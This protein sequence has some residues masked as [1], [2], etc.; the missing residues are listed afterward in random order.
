MKNFI[1]ALLLL[2]LFAHASEPLHVF[3]SVVPQKFFVEN[4]GGEH[5]SVDVLVRPGHNPATYNPTSRQMQRFAAADVLFRIGVPFESSWLGRLSAANETLEII[6]A[7]DGIETLQIAAHHGHADDHDEH[8]EHAETDP[9]I[10]TSPLVA[11]KM[12]IQIKQVLSRLQPENAAYFEARYQ[13]LQQQLQQLHTVIS[14]QLAP[15]AGQKFIVFHPSWGYFADTYQLEQV[16]IEVDG[17][18][19]N[20]RML[21]KQVKQAHNEDIHVIFIQPQFSQQTARA[22]ADAIDGEIITIDPLAEDYIHNME[23]VARQ[24]AD[25]FSR[26]ATR[27]Q[28][29]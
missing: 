18:Q 23:K 2:P 26:T 29:K 15:Y 19:P 12:L 11:Q 9:H 27:K 17:K 22:F 3:V 16:A 6:D 25:H 13:H 14:R 21:S 10:W 24:L 4:I 20:A 8:A 28:H 5:V 7:R 1:F